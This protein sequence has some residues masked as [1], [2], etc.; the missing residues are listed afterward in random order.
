MA[1]TRRAGSPGAG[2]AENRDFRP[3]RL[4]R[5]PVRGLRPS[6]HHACD[7]GVRTPESLGPEV[8]GKNGHVIRGSPSVTYVWTPHIGAPAKEPY[9]HMSDQ[10]LLRRRQLLKAGAA[11]AGFLALGGAGLFSAAPV[12]QRLLRAVSADQLYIEV[13]P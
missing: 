8:K 1:A 6:G 2:L 3:Y 9:P 12:A 13:F 10:F 5:L 11:G 7:L 4:R